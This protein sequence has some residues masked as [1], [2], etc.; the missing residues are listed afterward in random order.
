VLWN[1]VG[2]WQAVVWVNSEVHS[3]SID[4]RKLQKISKN[5]KKLVMADQIGFV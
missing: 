1:N 3:F 4:L 2:P 5:F